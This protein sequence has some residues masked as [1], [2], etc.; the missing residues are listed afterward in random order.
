MLHTLRHS[1]CYMIA[2]PFS[3]AISAT[4]VSAQSAPSTFETIKGTWLQC[5]WTENTTSAMDSPQFR[6]SNEKTERSAI[7]KFVN[8]M[9]NILLY[10]EKTQTLDLSS[11]IVVNNEDIIFPKHYQYA[12]DSIIDTTEG[13]ILID[14]RTLKLSGG[15]KTESTQTVDGVK[16]H[17]VTMVASSG[18]CKIIEP[19]E[20]RRALF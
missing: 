20:V 1:P 14:R 19:R 11:S 16:L 18:D 5:S 17:I 9:S 13:T 15:S 8:T 10:D 6:Y 12:N 4:E 2:L 3:L 7:Y